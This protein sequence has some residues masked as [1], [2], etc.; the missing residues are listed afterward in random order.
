MCHERFEE[1][2]DLRRDEAT[3]R[4]DGEHAELWQR[5]VE[6]N[7]FQESGIEVPTRHETRRHR[8][9]DA[10]TRRRHQSFA[11]VAHH[12]RRYLDTD[13]AAA[14][15]CAG[16]PEEQLDKLRLPGLCTEDRCLDDILLHG[17]DSIVRD[18]RGNLVLVL[19]MLGNH[20][21]AYFKR[22]SD[23]YRRFTPTC[24]TGDLGK[25]SPQEVINAYDNALLYTDRV[26]T[27]I[28]AF[29]KAREPDSRPRCCTCRTHGESL[30]E[31]GLSI[32]TFS[33]SLGA[34][35]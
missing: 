21:P 18:T 30:G 2:A 5:P 3:M 8:E 1:H 23:A 27:N 35:A 4:V 33:C 11:V 13:L 31:G 32:G 28:V 34:I 25:C 14:G 15:V 29:L 20:G 24:D 17:L 22:Y 12:H 9:S 6:Q 19:H 26:L 7:R 16:L 10:P